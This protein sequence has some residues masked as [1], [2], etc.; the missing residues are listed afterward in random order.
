M[1]KFTKPSQ[2]KDQFESYHDERK[3][4]GRKRHEGGG[5]KVKSSTKWYDR[6]N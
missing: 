3:S 5:K 1:S 6:M 4:R 2:E